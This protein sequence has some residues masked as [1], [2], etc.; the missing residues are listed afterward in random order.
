MTAKMVEMWRHMGNENNAPLSYVDVA[1]TVIN[2]GTSI[3][4]C[5]D[6]SPLLSCTH[7]HCMSQINDPCSCPG[8]TSWRSW[9][10]QCP[11]S[12]TDYGGGPPMMT[13]PY[14]S[15]VLSKAYVVINDVQP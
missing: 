2:G 10:D 9:I 12:G 7:C 5:G 1:S 14:S 6:A 3:E 8:A 11:A 4:M 13:I 15:L